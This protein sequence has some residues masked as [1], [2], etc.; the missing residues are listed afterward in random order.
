MLFKGQKRYA[1]TSVTLDG[2][3]KWSESEYEMYRAQHS[4]CDVESHPKLAGSKPGFAQVHQAQGAKLHFWGHGCMGVS[5]GSGWIGEYPWS[6]AFDEART[7]CD[8]PDSW[9]EST[10]IRHTPRR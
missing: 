7:Y 4:S 1:G 2:F 5:L 9:V 8:Q 3:W 10:G 6:R